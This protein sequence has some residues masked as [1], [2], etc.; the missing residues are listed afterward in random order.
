MATCWRTLNAS[1]C[2]ECLR[3]AS[4]AAAG[5]LPWTEG[6]VANTGCFLRYSDTDFLNNSTSTTRSSSGH[7]T[8]K[9]VA[10]GCSVAAVG[11]GVIIRIIIYKRNRAIQDRRK[12]LTKV[13]KMIISVLKKSS[14][15]FKYSMLEKATGSFGEANK[16]GE[17][18]FGTVYKGV[19][20]DGRE[21]AVKRLFFNNRS[22][23]MDFFNEV[24]LISSVEHKN[25][26]RL[27]GCSCWG[28]ESL[29]V[30]EYLPNKSLDRFIFDEEI[31]NVLDWEKRFK[32]ITGTA[33]GLAHLH[34]NPKARIIHKDIKASNVL[35]DSKFQAKIPYFGLARSFEEDKTH[36]STAI[37]GTLG[38]M[39]P[40]YIA[41]GQLSEKADV[42]SF[43][44]LVLE[45]ISGRQNCRSITSEHSQ[46]LLT[47]AWNHFQ[48]GTAEDLIDPNI[49]SLQHREQMLR[50]VHVAFLCMQECQNLRPSMSVC[51][52]MLL[53]A[54]E[55]LP[56]PTNPPFTDEW[57][58]E[59]DFEGDSER[60]LSETSSSAASVATMMYSAF[61]PR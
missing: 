22:R 31:G 39:A 38:Y 12:G 30:Y 58:M 13:S 14:L 29:L 19:L 46:S 52:Q 51:L 7:K 33:Q 56:A 16:L 44:V 1:G 10:V 41:H 59:F 8:V 21:V 23:A 43:G 28:P 50:A 4:A 53:R 20:A 42:Y 57:T 35:L 24:R 34:E 25:L 37:A 11:L 61:Y 45:I 5:C 47:L 26:V 6:R 2:G 36:V 32:I 17:G 3:N 9:V 60:L 27:L 54:E 55:P 48:T 18:G 15:N 40:E 49:R